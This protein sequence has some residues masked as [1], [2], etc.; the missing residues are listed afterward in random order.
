MRI[1]ENS[2]YS[3]LR[4]SEFKTFQDTATLGHGSNPALGDA[5]RTRAASR[6]AEAAYADFGAP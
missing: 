3:G 2:I 5:E 1:N 6:S 4:F